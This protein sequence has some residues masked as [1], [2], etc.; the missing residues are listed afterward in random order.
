MREIRPSGSEGGGDRRVS[1]YLYQRARTP[2]L[3]LRCAMG[4]WSA[5][6]RPAGAPASRA[7]ARRSELAEKRWRPRLVA[8]T[9][10]LKGHGVES[11]P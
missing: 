11:L 5:G 4:L 6:L 10:A 8:R 7:G 3:Q 1:P 9:P 2:T